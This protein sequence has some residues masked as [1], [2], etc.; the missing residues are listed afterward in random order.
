[1]DNEIKLPQP[2]EVSYKEKERA[3]ASYFMMFASSTIGLPLP[4]FNLIASW[5][6]YRYTSKT[7]QFVRFHSYQSML[8]QL[9]ITV[10]NTVIVFWTLNIVWGNFPMANEND[11]S[12]ILE[13]FSSNYIGF[14]IVTALSNLIYIIFSVIAGAK[15]YKGR[16]YYFP[17]FGNI[18]FDHAFVNFKEFGK[19]EYV[20]TAPKL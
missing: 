10:F 17:Y 8:S 9:P 2:N 4:F 16:L 12:P 15:A 13:G 5:I 18:A 19:E 20:N 6:F 7:S 14:A 1:M 11:L 3:M